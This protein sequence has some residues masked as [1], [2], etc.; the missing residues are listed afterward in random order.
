[1]S[2]ADVSAAVVRAYRKQLH[3]AL[4]LWHAAPRPTREDFERLRRAQEMLAS[5]KAQHEKDKACDL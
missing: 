5:A 1:M 4:D 2:R 3:D